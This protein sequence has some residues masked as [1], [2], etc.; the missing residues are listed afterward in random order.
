M[1]IFSKIPTATGL[2]IILVLLSLVGLF[3]VFQA[4]T[5]ESFNLY[6]HQYYFI[7]RQI[8]WLLIGVIAFLIAYFTPIKFWLKIAPFV[9]LITFLALV[10]TLVPS[11]GI[12]V[13]GAKRWI[14]LGI[15]SFQPVE[16]FKLGLIVFFASWLKKHQR[17]LPFIFLISLPAVILLLQPDIGS[18]LVI[19]AIATGMFFVAGGN[20]KKLLPIIGFGLVLL[21]VAILASPYRL[22]RIQTF[23]N[24][25]VDPLGASFQIRQITLALGSGGW[26]GLGLGNSQQKHAFIPE[27]SSDSIFA[28]V[29]EELGFI[30]SCFILILFGLY[31][32]LIYKTA[33]AQKKYSFEQLFTSGVL[34]WIAGQTV[35]NLGSIVALLPLTGLPLPLFSYGGSSLVSVLFASGFVYKVAKSPKK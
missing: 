13:N 21:I 25:E 34:L 9:Y 23:L 15:T 7:T 27:L 28:I 31:F 8:I 26:F 11:I 22:R 17:I 6:G 32:Y 3:F 4:S 35:L 20:I 18:L 12:E 19:L 24:P 5:I 29:A 10:L 14:D 16:F 1:K 30:G 2:V 33:I